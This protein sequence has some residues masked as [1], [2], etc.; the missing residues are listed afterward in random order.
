[1]EPQAALPTSAVSLTFRLQIFKLRA[2]SNSTPTDQAMIGETVSH[3]R[4]LEKL[5][6]GGM[7][8]VYRA[9][10]L[11]LGRHVALKFLPDSAAADAQAIERFRREARA[12]AALNH[13]S[14][15]S[16]YEI[17]EHEGHW[18]IVMELLEG[19]TLKHR[20][21]GQG[22][23]T[24]PLL[25][26]A[27]QI[28]E[29]LDAA[30]SKG[31]IHRDI[32]PTNIFVTDRGHV[33]ILD[34]GVAKL[35]AAASPTLSS[36]ETP[37]AMID[38]EHLTSAGVTVGTVSYMSPEQAKGEELDA[39]SDLFSFGAVLYE[40]ATGRQAFGGASTAAI[41]T[42]IL[43]DDPQSPS[44]ANPELPVV[45]DRIIARALAKDRRLR[46]Q[47]GEDIR[48]DLKRLQ[49]DTT[50]DRLAA[51]A[52]RSGATG[53]PSSSK[54]AAIVPA[55]S[56]SSDSEVI[57]GLVR[58][59]K[60]GV[61]ATTVILV[62]V[63]AA[64]AY[65]LF[66]AA[67]RSQP[68]APD[69]L[70][71]TRVTSSGDVQRADI[72]PDGKYVAYVRWS[73]G[74]DTIWLRQLATDRAVQI[75]SLGDDYCRGLGFSPEGSYI[76]FVRRTPLERSGDLYQV[77]TLGGTPRRMLAGLSGSPAF[78]PDG[79]RVAFVRDTNSDD[80]LVVASLDG[81]S[82]HVLVSYQRPEGISPYRAAWSPD[83]KTLAF[84]HYSPNWVL[85][86]IPADGGPTQA[87]TGAK[88]F[89]GIEDITWLPER[90]H[91][92]LAGIFGDGT[93]PQLYE[94]SLEARAARQ[95]TH[96]LANYGGARVTADG[97][98]LVAIRDQV[99]MAIEVVTPGRESEARSVSAGNQ[100]DDGQSGL[101]WTPDG[102][103]VY[104]SAPNGASDFWEVAA[105]GST[106]SRLTSDV[107]SWNVGDPAV[108]PRGGFIVF[109]RWDQTIQTKIWRMDMDGSNLKQLSDGTQ[110]V[111]PAV[112]P[113]GKWVVFTR[114]AGGKYTLM[115]VSSEG[116]PATPLTDYALRAPSIS[117]DG[118]WIACE[119][120][121]G[122]NQPIGVALI[123]FEGG[124]PA[125][126]FALPRSYDQP[127]RWTP[128]GGAVSFTNSVSGVDNIWEQPVRGGPR[129]PVTHFTSGKIFYFDWS[130]DGRLA[131]A[132]GS[133][134]SD[135]VVIKSFH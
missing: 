2:P 9:E 5:G 21:K 18:F 88:D 120:F 11:N 56:D 48:A 104:F 57:A 103:I 24:E 81:S 60:K 110:D 30:H 69:A 44:Q 122:P 78:S 42:A 127:L 79:Q 28:A 13:P 14:I 115:K 75:A 49:R 38:A 83:G 40:M 106:R 96:D 76:Y 102:K 16:I 84:C 95:I 4:I 23:E 29:A 126:V 63:V 68:S 119:Y 94:F 128:D 118:K 121:P 32:K 15:C 46:Y 108:S 90:N 134:P 129:K 133:E 124:L 26:L 135:A 39:R 12:A 66:R 89:S 52:P 91:L 113:D 19:Q 98:T 130:R 31:I 99:F 74:K 17:G 71:F 22:L 35:T 77:P 86:T 41:F 62:I 111:L 132:R 107:G 27:I 3:Y 70:Q 47:G 43:R 92:L 53:S 82:E 7:G 101:S 105:D 8:V 64:I 67:G 125:K 116:G 59:H 37:T 1:M 50:S 123:P 80:S 109:T 117:P 85:T 6:G 55:S 93:T 34:F 131:L 51:A 58:R 73:E 36:D 25:E 20:I 72:S 54:T 10:D 65:A 114:L 100:D 112:S 97:N 45:L 87:V 33:K 61:A